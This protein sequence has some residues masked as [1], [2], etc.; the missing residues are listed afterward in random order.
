MKRPTASRTAGIVLAT[1]ALA[2][3]S[4]R[5]P[6]SSAVAATHAGHDMAGMSQAAMQ[7]VADGWFARHPVTPAAAAV[8]AADTF[9]AFGFT[10]DSDGN[11]ANIDTVRV[12]EGDN[13][14]WLWVSGSH[15]V[16]NG[17][18]S[19]DPQAG[20]LFNANLS[21]VSKQFSFTFET[22]GTYPFFCVFHEFAN[23]R[24]VVVVQ[25]LTGVPPSHP[26][27]SGFVSDPSPVPSRSGVTF[28]F[29]MTRAGR[30]RAEV[31]DVRGRRVAV[32]FDQ[33]RGVGTFGG[34]WDGRTG[35]GSRV[36]SGVYYLRLVLPGST[37]T[38]RVVIAD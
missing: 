23:S 19:G 9:L 27:G 28:R 15:T 24:G 36:A 37:A 20:V 21:S 32:A 13:V 3:I 18:G 16:T 4:A 7:R 29:A 30:A 25:S 22:A 34:A 26:H 5:S 14:L 38:R 2:C 6:H 1:L 17:T 11:S 31:F 33:E 10:F 12:F 8:S 35:A